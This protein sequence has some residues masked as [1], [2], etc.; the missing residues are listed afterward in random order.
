MSPF[1]INYRAIPI[2]AVAVDNIADPRPESA[3]FSKPVRIQTAEVIGNEIIGAN[4]QERP[5]AQY[6]YICI[7]DRQISHFGR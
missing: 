3:M 2:I 7:C 5:P 6:P 4:D 1:D